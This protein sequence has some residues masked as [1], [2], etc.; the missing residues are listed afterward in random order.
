MK[1]TGIS[2]LLLLV[3]ILTCGSVYAVPGDRPEKLAVLDLEAKYGVEDSMAEAYSVLVRDAIHSFGEYE[4]MSTADLRAVMSREALLQ[5]MGCDDN[6]SACLV[7]FGRAIGTR[8]M[9]AGSLSK[10]GSTY[11]ISLRILDTKG[12]NA[13]VVKRASGSCKCS[14]DELIGAVQ[15]TAA[16]LMGRGKYSA[17]EEEASRKKAVALEAERKNLAAEIER[18]KD[19]RAEAAEVEKKLLIAE[20]KELELKITAAKKGV[21]PDVERVTTNDQHNNS[22]AAS[23]NKEKQQ[24]RKKSVALVACKFDGRGSLFKSDLIDAVAAF[25]ER[26]RN[27]YTL[28]YSVINTGSEVRYA[29]QSNQKNKSNFWVK[30]SIF[31]DYIPDVKKLSYAAKNID[32]DIILLYHIAYDWPEWRSLAYLFDSKNKSL[33]K[34]TWLQHGFNPGQSSE[35]SEQF[36]RLTSEVF[37]KFTD[38]K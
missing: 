36:E 5:A 4:V 32:A 27:I 9:V 16:E 11:S 24:F 20:S 28:K 34:R 38:K 37:L 6:G 15:K 29:D 7:N 10:L 25:F 30:E 33:H 19:E 21:F 23:N 3:L 26:N 35:T 18:L 12:E 22:F 8:F 17:K 1:I 14:E 31:S 2:T 13:G